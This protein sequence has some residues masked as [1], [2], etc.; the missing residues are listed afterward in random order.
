MAGAVGDVARQVM[1]T[2]VY[3]ARVLA[4]EETFRRLLAADSRAGAPTA[5][6]D[7]IRFSYSGTPADAADLLGRLVAA[8][9]RVAAFGPR[10]S[11]LEEMFLRLGTR[12][13]S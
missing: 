9:V 11:G 7:G 8:G 2:A 12:E 3:E 5:E 13:L 6:A 1:G 10:Q 4:G